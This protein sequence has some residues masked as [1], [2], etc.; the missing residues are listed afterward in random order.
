[1]YN[2]T[3]KAIAL[4]TTLTIPL[5][6]AVAIEAIVLRPAL[7]TGDDDD[8][9][10]ARLYQV[11]WTPDGQMVMAQG[12]VN[13]PARRGGGVY[14]YFWDPV[15]RRERMRLGPLGETADYRY[16]PI[17]HFLGA[18]TRFLIHRSEEV[19]IHETATGKKIG[20]IVT[21][22]GA[23]KLLSV[24]ADGKMMAIFRFDDGA[25]VEIV[26]LPEGRKKVAWPCSDDVSD[27]AFTPDGKYLA[28]SRSQS[29]I[30]LYDTRTWQHLGTLRTT[31]SVRAMVISSDGKMLAAPKLNPNVPL[32]RIPSLEPIGWAPHFHECH[33]D[34]W[35]PLVPEAIAFT[36]DNAYLAASFRDGRAGMVGLWSVGSR[37]PAGLIQPQEVPGLAP[38]NWLAFSPDGKYL[39]GVNIYDDDAVRIWEWRQAISS[40]K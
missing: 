4:W 25:S 11:G 13:E 20:S 15:A 7:R 3:L 26:D 23:W 34:R 12:E 5:A 28:V 27:V 1:M 37:E 10:R 29:R 19:T 36:P 21:P 6:P 8:A 32:W 18:G 31:D 39:A 16:H 14:V 17:V 33:N 40:G 35:D 22:R 24:S 9:P 38:E 2:V 30:K